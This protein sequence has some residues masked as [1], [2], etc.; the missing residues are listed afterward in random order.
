MSNFDHYYALKNLFVV[1]TVTS[2]IGAGGILFTSYMHVP[3][4]VKNS[5][6]DSLL[7]QWQTMGAIGRTAL[8]P[9]AIVAAGANF[10]NGYLTYGQPQTYRFVAAGALSLSILP[11]TFVALGET[12]NAL[13]AKAE[14]KSTDV[15]ASGTGGDLRELIN[16]WSNRSAVRGFLLLASAVLSYDGMLHLTF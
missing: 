5:S 1:G 9:L 11:Y 8:P 10:I 2:A 4:Y 14:K 6:D 3:A 15:A 16:T 13:T 12:N 7:T